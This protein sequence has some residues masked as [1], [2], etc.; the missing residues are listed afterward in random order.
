VVRGELPRLL[1]PFA[2]LDSPWDGE[3][4][5]DPPRVVET[6]IGDLIEMV[7]PQRV[8]LLLALGAYSL[9]LLEIVRASSARRSL[10]GRRK[11]AA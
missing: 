11:G 6:P 10:S 3:R 2:A 8:E 7:D 9:D 1:N 5:A 4:R